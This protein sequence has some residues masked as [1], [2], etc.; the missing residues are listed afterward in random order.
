MSVHYNA[1]SMDTPRYSK[2]QESIILK[3]FVVVVS[4]SRDCEQFSFPNDERNHDECD[5]GSIDHSTKGNSNVLN[6]QIGESFVFGSDASTKKTEAQKLV[7]GNLQIS[8]VTK[9]LR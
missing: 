3:G 7:L 5:A 2:S 8:F 1:L 4:F 9:G 6:C